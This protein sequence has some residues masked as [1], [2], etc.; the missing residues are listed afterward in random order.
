[1]GSDG[2]SGEERSQDDLREFLGIS[3]ETVTELVSVGFE[4]YVKDALRDV[5]T[6]AAV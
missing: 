3:E 2:E 6:K 4:E 1:M 5:R